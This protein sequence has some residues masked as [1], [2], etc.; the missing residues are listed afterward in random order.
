[1]TFLFECQLTKDTVVTE[2][3]ADCA[4]TPSTPSATYTKTYTGLDQGDYV[5]SARATDAIGRVSFPVNK[6]WTV[7]APADTTP[8]VVTVTPVGTPGSTASFTL[9]AN[10]DPVTFECMLT[11][12]GVPGLWEGCTS[13]KTY[14]DLLPGDVHLLRPGDGRGPER[15]GRR[16]HRAGRWRRLPTP[17]L[18][19]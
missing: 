16:H 1:M 5:F 14:S 12:N 11:T 8:P 18:R 17:R 4:S 6:S 13:P 10:E 15:L 3:W 7:A 9:T 2:P 19:S